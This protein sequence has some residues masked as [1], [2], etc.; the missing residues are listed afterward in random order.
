MP[1]RLITVQGW[2]PRSIP[3]RRQAKD[4]RAMAGWI[5]R[6]CVLKDKGHLNQKQR[7]VNRTHNGQIVTFGLFP[8]GGRTD[9]KTTT[10]DVL[11]RKERSTSQ[12]THRQT[13]RHKQ[14]ETESERDRETNGQTDRQRYRERAREQDRAR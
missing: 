7:A 10:M 2:G 4:D 3:E 14:T 13:D 9:A 11:G 5:L 12:Y 8:T 6:G 1:V